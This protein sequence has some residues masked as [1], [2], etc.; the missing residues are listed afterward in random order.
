[1]PTRN[2]GTCLR[3]SSAAW[4]GDG[5]AVVTAASAAMPAR[6]APNVRRAIIVFSLNGAM[7]LR[8]GQDAA[9]RGGPASPVAAPL[10]VEVALTLK[11]G[12]ASCRE[13][14]CPSVYI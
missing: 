12:R 13:S 4:A 2:T 5:A 11:H 3:Q 1:M 14:V 7:G 6:A 9:T 10:E 8:G